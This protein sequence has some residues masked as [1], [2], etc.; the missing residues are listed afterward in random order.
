MRQEKRRRQFVF[1]T[2]NANLPVLADAELILGLTAYGEAAGGY[3]TIEQEHMGAIDSRP[4]RALV[5][6]VL[7]GGRDAFQMRRSK[8]G[9]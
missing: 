2:H 4:V 9:F 5:E 8:Y 6:D 1:S 7:E 3:A